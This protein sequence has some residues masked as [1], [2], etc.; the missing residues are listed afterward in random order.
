MSLR[1]ATDQSIIVAASTTG[2]ADRDDAT[3]IRFPWVQLPPV[4]GVTGDT[5]TTCGK[6]LVNRQTDQTTI[7]IVTASAAIVHP[8]I[9]RIGEWRRITVT[10]ATAISTRHGYQS[11]MINIRHR[12][13]I[14]E[15]RPMAI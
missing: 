8:W 11:D 2:S 1:C 14:G 3:V 12:V 7:Q 9:E 15:I 4:R 5:V 6:G 10:S 13:K